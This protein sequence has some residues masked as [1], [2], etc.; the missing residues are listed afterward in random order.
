MHEIRSAKMGLERVINQYVQC[1]VMSMQE[2]LQA[3]QTQGVA[4]EVKT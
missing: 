3:T 1:K 4:M 2:P